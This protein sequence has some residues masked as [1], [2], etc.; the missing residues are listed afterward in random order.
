MR[1]HQGI[2]QIDPIR[3]L[4]DLIVGALSKIFVA[5]K[6]FSEFFERNRRKKIIDKK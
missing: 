6:M 4:T 1:D 3:G 2:L 5:W